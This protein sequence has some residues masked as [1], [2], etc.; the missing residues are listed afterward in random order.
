MKALLMWAT[1]VIVAFGALAGVTNATRGTEQV[2]VVVDTSFEMQGKEARVTA[3]LDRIDDRDYAEFALAT[4]ARLSSGVHG[5]Q[6]EL[7]WEVVE[8]VGPCSFDDIESFPEASS[9]D[10]RI[11]I[12]SV[13]SCDTSGLDGWTIID[14]DG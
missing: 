6:D 13:A 7:D 8:A 3:E 9:A 12:T 2:F 4:V 5:Y 10:E 14:V 1:G 11:L